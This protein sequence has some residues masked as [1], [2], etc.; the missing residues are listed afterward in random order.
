MAISLSVALPRDHSARAKPL[1]VPLGP[2][3]RIVL[4]V[5]PF[6]HAFRGRGPSWPRFRVTCRL[7]GI[8]GANLVAVRDTAARCG[9]IWCW[10]WPISMV[11]PPSC[12]RAASRVLKVCN[13]VQNA[14][15][16]NGTCYRGL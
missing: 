1:T 12:Q 13:W 8:G 14:L 2:A 10:S 16:F 4:G 3:G 6:P 11:G 9:D 5:D 15:C 7:H